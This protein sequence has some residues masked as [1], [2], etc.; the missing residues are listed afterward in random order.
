MA[1][2]KGFIS[3]A[4]YDEA[5]RLLQS[6]TTARL[7]PHSAEC[8]GLITTGRQRN[9]TGGNA[10]LCGGLTDAK[11]I[12]HLEMILLSARTLIGPTFRQR[13]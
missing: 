13:T 9:R 7:V 2:A 5:Y 1:N 12:C 3:N 11:A 10:S 8:G 4:G 6:K